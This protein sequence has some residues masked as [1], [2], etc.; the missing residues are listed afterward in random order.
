MNSSRV[1]S[2]VILAGGQSSRFGSQKSVA[3]LKGVR[4]IDRVIRSLESQSAKRVVINA[5]SPQTGAAAKYVRVADRAPHISGPLAGIRAALQWAEE[6]GLKRVITVPTDTP[7]LPDNLLERFSAET[8]AGV[9][10]SD[11]LLH[12]TTGV[13]PTHLLP[14]LNAFLKDGHRTAAA[15]CDLCGA[16]AIKFELENGIDPFFNIN[17]KEDLLC[18]ERLMSV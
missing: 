2:C 17:T 18:A 12:P 3:L 16:T 9:A 8:G 6:A 15:W 13:W 1:L 5:N 7:F 11:Q 10:M 4:L 14:N